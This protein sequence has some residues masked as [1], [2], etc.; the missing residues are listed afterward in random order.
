MTDPITLKGVSKAFRDKRFRNFQ[1]LSDVTL[2]VHQGEAFGF[3]GPNGA[4]KSTTIKILT[5]IIAADRGD[6]CMF[7]ISVNDHHARKGMSYVPESPYL[8]DY[9]T[10]LEML[11]MGCRMH[12]LQE[13]GLEAHCMNILERFSI[14]HVANKRI[15]HF[16][17]GMT[18]RTA[19]A[20]ALACKPKLLILD[21]PLSG[22]DPIGRKDVVDI[23]LQYRNDGGT[24]FFSSH[25]LS[26][27]QRLGDRFGLIHKGV[28][29]AV[30]TLGDLVSG[31]E[32]FFVIR[33]LGTTA[34]EGII[35][36]GTDKWKIQ[37]NEHDLVEWLQRL[38]GAGHQIMDVQRGPTLEQAFLRFIREAEGGDLPRQ[39]HE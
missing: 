34:L 9:L 30:N 18:Q 8:Y 10:P 3:I 27:V 36:E 26:D 6:A 22:L 38:K 33:T 32:G 25:V 4:G 23:L 35:S 21:E 17:K 1:A 13:K 19:L 24:I 15:R 16:S 12:G 39:V 11:L 29:R 37:V 14:A 28:L 2:D 31:A 5:G 7:G 20:H